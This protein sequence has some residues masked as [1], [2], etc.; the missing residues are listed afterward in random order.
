[1]RFWRQLR[2]QFV[3]ATIIVVLVGV[4]VLAIAASLALD[5]LPTDV[6]ANLAALT[7][8]DS[9]AGE[10]ALDEAMTA[11]IMATVRRGIWQSLLI[12]A[13][14]ATLAGLLTSILLSREILRPL[15]QIA[16]SSKRIADGH[17]GERVAV[18]YSDELALVATNFNQMAESL[19]QTELQRVQM[20][21]DVAHELRTPLTGLRGYLEGLL[22]GL[23]PPESETFG[24]MYQEV[25]RLQRLV[26]DL[27]TLSRV[28]AG[29]IELHP[30]RFDLV[31][32]VER[33]TTQVRPQV[34]AENQTLVTDCNDAELSVYADPD[35]TAQVLVNLISNAI[36]YTPEGG[37]ITVCVNREGRFAAINVIDTGVGLAPEELSR[38]F[39]RFYR[40]DK[41]RS[42]RSG[43]SGI[44]LTIAQHLAWAMGGE[45]TVSSEGAGKGSSFGF[46]LP[47]A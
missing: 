20:I 38:I 8:A 10:I 44:G 6:Q 42:R 46:T 29:N 36:R 34:V 1:M 41:A 16:V 15:G 9:S 11:E 13:I 5:S 40:V 23:F 19:E 14:A 2:W 12:A 3:G 25:R 47:L 4:V 17:Y 45:V 35:R 21:G 24:H 28:E 31:K 30:Q 26:D 7:A 39:E 32:L 37:H 22:D 18:P 27:Q 43:G 33:V